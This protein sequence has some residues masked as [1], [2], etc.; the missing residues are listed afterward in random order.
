MKRLLAA[1]AILGLTLAAE[2]ATEWRVAPFQAFTQRTTQPDGGKAN[3][4]ALCEPEIVSTVGKT[5]WH[6]LKGTSAPLARFAPCIA[7]TIP[8]PVPAP[9]PIPTPTP[10][11]TPTPAPVPVP[12]LGAPAIFYT[13]IVTGPNSGGEGN[14]GAYLTLFGQGFGSTQGNSVVTIGGTAVAAYKQWSDSKI[15]VQPGPGVLGGAVKISVGGIGQVISDQTFTVVPGKIWFVSLAGNDSTCVAGDITKPCRLI[16]QT[17]ERADFTP[18]D[19]LVVRG[20]TWSDVYAQYGSFFSIHHKGGTAAA[21]MAFMGYPGESVN[22]VQTTQGRGI[23][24]FSTPGHW[25][26]SNFHIDAKR[27][28][29]SIAIEPNTDDIRVVG[30]EITGFFEDSGGAA[31]IEG[32]GTRYRILGNNLHDNGGSKL[33][34]GIYIDCRAGTVNDI[35]V[36]WNSVSNQTGGRGIQFY[37]DVD[38]RKMTNVVAHDNLVHDIHLDG[39]IYSSNTGAGAKAF[40]NVVYRTGNPAFKGPSTDAG[41]SGGCIRFASSALSIVV[42]NNTFADCGMDG[43]P[44]SASIRFDTGAGITLRDNIIADKKFATGAP[45]AGSSASGNVWFGAPKPV[46]DATGIS[47]DPLFLD[48]ANYDLRLAP[49]SPALG[50]GAF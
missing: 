7:V 10:V 22:F 26:V 41:E 17:F 18:G 8:D 2:A 13:D 9:V 16:T 25:V 30:N 4:G 15:T 40:R 45:G 31:A 12:A 19:H 32:S 29:I 1:A 5:T 34:H 3:V 36:G 49:A 48:R 14:F 43:T 38:T 21:P 39:I 35:E 44:D 42:S 27:H 46:W 47:V 28:G 33:Y 20:G 11:P 37:C 6:L 50:K 24:S 23:H